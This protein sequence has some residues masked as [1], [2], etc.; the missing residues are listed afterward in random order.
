MRA[1]PAPRSSNAALVAESEIATRVRRSL[2]VRAIAAMAL[3]CAA[4][5]PLFR[6]GWL[7]ATSFALTTLL[8]FAGAT[9]FLGL[10]F[11]RAAREIAAREGELKTAHDQAQR[12]GA[13]SRNLADQ[14]ARAQRIARVGSWEWNRAE[15]SLFC[16][17]EA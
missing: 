11:A 16:S 7:D 5:F 9:V 15:D 3:P 12:E 17:S 10:S 8:L 4:L 2:L 1:R 6:A 14:L 13:E